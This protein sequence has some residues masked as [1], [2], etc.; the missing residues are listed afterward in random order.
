[1]NL[2]DHELVNIIVALKSLLNKNHR[3]IDRIKR[4]FDDPNTFIRERDIL[5]QRLLVEKF[6]MEQLRRQKESQ[7]SMH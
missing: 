1:M 4:K 2:Q 3:N 6:E 7:M 5:R